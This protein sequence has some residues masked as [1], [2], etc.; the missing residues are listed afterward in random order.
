M[1]NP[2]PDERARELWSHMQLHNP[3]VTAWD[4]IC[5][6]TETLAMLSGGEGGYTFLQEPVKK[7]ISVVY[8]AHNAMDA[9]PTCLQQLSPSVQE[10]PKLTDK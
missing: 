7:L 9:M 10:E 6:C 5:F 4:L 2:P 1:H 3:R 8:T